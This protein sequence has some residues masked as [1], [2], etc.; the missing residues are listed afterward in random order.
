MSELFGLLVFAIASGV[1]WYAVS[2][3]GDISECAKE[4]KR[5][6]DAAEK[7]NDLYCKKEGINRYL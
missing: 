4:L 3:I 6:A 5:I 2:S 1:V 7:K